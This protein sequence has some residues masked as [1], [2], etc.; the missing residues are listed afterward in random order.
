MKTAEELNNYGK[1]LVEIMQDLPND[2]LKRNRAEGLHFI[3]KKLG[4]FK[5]LELIVLFLWHKK[6]L[7]NKDLSELRSGEVDA[8]VLISFVLDRTALFVTL[9]TLIGEQEAIDI[10]QEMSEV[11]SHL[12]EGQIYPSVKDLEQLTDPFEGV[13]QF[14]LRGFEANKRDGI[15][16]FEIAE[17]NE[18][19]FRLNCTYCAFAEIPRLL[20][21]SSK[22]A[23]PSC[24][25]DDIVF[26]KWRD[27]LGIAFERNNT[28]ARGGQ[29]CDFKYQRL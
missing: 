6:R 11:T 10:L 8:K 23:I 25:Y 13:K 17:D 29:V 24:Y 5:F 20:T 28:I 16:D 22:P 15:H 14:F 18:D 12:M 27:K 2:I 4:L 19:T 26:P 7:S 9:E 21:G 3:R 1:S